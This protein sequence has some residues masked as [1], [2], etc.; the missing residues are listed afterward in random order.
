MNISLTSRAQMAA[1]F[2]AVLALSACGSSGSDTSAPAPS[3]APAPAPAPEPPA[4]APGPAPAP[5]PSSV[6]A[7]A[8]QGRWLASASTPNYTLIV[9]P[10]VGESAQVWALAQ[11]SSSLAKLSINSGTALAMTGKSYSLSS[12]ITQT[13]S[14]LSGSATA[15]ISSNP[16][17][18]SLTGLSNTS[19][20]FTQNDALSTPVLQAD[21]AANW[22]ASF[23]QGS[24]VVN[25]TVS[26]TGAVSGNS[27]TGC[28]WSGN[29]LTQNNTSVYS[30][31]LTE[32]CATGST[33]LEGIATTN[34]SK[35][36][37]TIAATS[38]DQS[39]GTALQMVKV[40]P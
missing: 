33:S 37:L 35:T 38:V 17:T 36:Q 8:L 20:A 13:V 6:A 27:N 1:L 7:S 29:L 39:K 11:D 12:T 19:I 40:N 28:T 25:W 32:S 2:A 23:N 3:P 4:P 22:R 31:N 30:A 14:T 24:Q 15:V 26:P 16:K 10:A 18:L 21:L 34:A 9:L 5:A